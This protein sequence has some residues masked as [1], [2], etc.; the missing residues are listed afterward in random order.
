ML[1]K[2][3]QLFSNKPY[4]RVVYFL[5]LLFIFLVTD[6]LNLSTKSYFGIRYKVSIV[7]MVAILANIL[8]LRYGFQMQW[9]I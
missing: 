7:G 1:A 4:E 8:L 5:P 9:Y 6:S 2:H 3:L